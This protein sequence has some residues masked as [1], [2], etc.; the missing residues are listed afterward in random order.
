MR[1]VCVIKGEK[2]VG[3]VLSKTFMHIEPLGSDLK[4]IKKR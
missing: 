4:P 3:K 1:L 2:M